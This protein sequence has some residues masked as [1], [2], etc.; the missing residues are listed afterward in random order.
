MSLGTMHCGKQKGRRGE[1]KYCYCCAL[2]SWSALARWAISLFL[3]SFF[4]WIP[5]KWE[6]NCDLNAVD[7]PALF[8]NYFSILG[9]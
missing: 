2:L 7:K 1:R 5:C 4:F 8:T 3:F 9:V 6:E